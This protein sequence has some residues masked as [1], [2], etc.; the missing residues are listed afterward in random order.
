MT[1]APFSSRN[2]TVSTRLA[3]KNNSTERVNVTTGIYVFLTNQIE[4]QNAQPKHSHPLDTRCMFSRAWLQLHVFP[5]LEPVSCFPHLRTVT[6][7][8]LHVF[9][10]LAPAVCFPALSA[11]YIF[12]RAR[13][14]LPHVFP[15]LAQVTCFTE[16][17][18]AGS[19]LTHGAACIFL[20]DDASCIF[21]LP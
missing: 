11:G 21:S 5:R 4:K 12:S 3:L 20:V 6:L 17:V 15:R 13:H 18:L 14:R 10:S 9:S 7:H 19:F 1:E 2:L 8:R 16:F